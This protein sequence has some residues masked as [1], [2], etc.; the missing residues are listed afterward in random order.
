MDRL[1]FTVEVWWS[2]SHTR[3]S[4]RNALSE[5]GGTVEQGKIQNPVQ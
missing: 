1:Q 2:F 4:F 5:I 3:L